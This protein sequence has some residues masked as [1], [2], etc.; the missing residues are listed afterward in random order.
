MF[1]LYFKKHSQIACKLC[2]YFP[3]FPW[4]MKEETSVMHKLHYKRW[5]TLFNSR[6]PIQDQ[7]H[8]YFTFWC[9]QRNKNMQLTLQRKAVPINISALELAISVYW[10]FF[11][12]RLT[13]ST[14]LKEVYHTS[15][16][17]PCFTVHRQYQ[18]ICNGKDRL[19]GISAKNLYRHAPTP[20]AISDTKTAISA[21]ALGW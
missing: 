15:Y 3:I 21:V 4:S 19:I 9:T 8:K 20:K 14:E 11:P 10:H 5:F 12:Y 6:F 2:V 1:L 17:L 7:F 16:Y 13:A 18:H